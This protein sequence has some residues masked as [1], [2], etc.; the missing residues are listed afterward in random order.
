[1]HCTQSASLIFF[2]VNIA[3]LDQ[4]MFEDATQNRM[5]DSLQLFESFVNDQSYTEVPIILI[6]NRIDSLSNKW[7]RHGAS[8]LKQAFPNDKFDNGTCN[9]PILHFMKRMS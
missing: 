8:M 7:N 2:V 4:V 6:F 3:Q 5:A 9:L 1:M